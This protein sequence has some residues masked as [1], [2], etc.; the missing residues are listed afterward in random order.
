MKK[1]ANS[2]FWLKWLKCQIQSWTKLPRNTASGSSRHWLMATQL[3]KHTTCC[4]ARW[5]AVPSLTAALAHWKSWGR[6][7]ESP[8]QPRYDARKCSVEGRGA[9]SSLYSHIKQGQQGLKELS[10]HKVLL[11]FME[12]QL[13]KLRAAWDGP[14]SEATQSASCHQ[15]T[16]SKLHELH[17]GQEWLTHLVTTDR[18]AGT[19]TYLCPWE[20]IPS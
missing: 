17:A 14:V 18:E 7:S 11:L 13:I 5:R 16:I 1:V 3:H 6:G 15:A 8:C 19:K 20:A 4:D 12:T 2:A 9:A 10:C